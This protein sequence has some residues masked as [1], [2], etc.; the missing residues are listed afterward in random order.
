MKTFSKPYRLVCARMHLLASAF[1][2]CMPGHVIAQTAWQVDIRS[3]AGPVA[4]VPLPSAG[5]KQRIAIVAFE[6]ERRCDPV[7]SIIEM[8]GPKLGQPLAQTVLAGSKIGIVLNGKFHTWHAAT[9]KYANGYEAGFGVT[10]DVFAKLT[11]DVG[12]LTFVAPEG[13]HYPLPIAGLRQSLQ[14]AVK[15]H[16]ELTP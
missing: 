6:Y 7:F 9:R 12:S 16:Q 1:V 15:R 8:T 3:P 14:G 2:A 5:G 4:G 10:N 13:D 11:G